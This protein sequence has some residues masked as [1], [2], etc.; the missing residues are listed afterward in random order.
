MPSGRRVMLQPRASVRA[1]SRARIRA[2]TASRSCGP[3]RRGLAGAE[4]TTSRRPRSSSR[5][6]RPARHRV[7]L[8][9]QARGVVV[10]PQRRPARP[11][12][13]CAGRCAC[14]VTARRGVGPRRAAAAARTAT[15]AQVRSTAA[16]VGRHPLDERTGARRRRLQ[17]GVGDLVGDA[18]V[19]L[20]AEPGAAPAP[21]TR[22][23]PGRPPRCRTWPGRCGRRRPG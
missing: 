12:P 8:P 15:A 22:R 21:G 2:S 10:E 13:T 11:R 16:P 19:D 23:W 20:V 14:V 5:R 17:R 4:A 9:P 1:G 3:R 6:S 18:A 7:T